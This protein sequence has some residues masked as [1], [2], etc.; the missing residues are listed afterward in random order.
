MQKTK[1]FFAGAAIETVLVFLAHE[2]F[3][4]GEQDT[5]FINRKETTRGFPSLSHAHFLPLFKP[6]DF[7]FEK[8]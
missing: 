7:H 8:R 2:G 4:Q 6:S 5:V 1:V 3:W